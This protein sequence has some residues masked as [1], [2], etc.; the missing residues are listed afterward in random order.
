MYAQGVSLRRG[1]YWKETPGRT[2][3]AKEGVLGFFEGFEGWGGTAKLR[4]GSFP[5]GLTFIPNG[6]QSIGILILSWTHWGR[7]DIPRMSLSCSPRNGDFEAVGT[8]ASKH[9][10]RHYQ[11]YP[12]AY[13][14]TILVD[15]KSGATSRDS[16]A[17]SQCGTLLFCP[18]FWP[19]SMLPIKILQILFLLLFSLG[20]SEN[21]GFFNGW[22]LSHHRWNRWVD[23]ISLYGRLCMLK[24]SW[25]WRWDRIVSS[26][27][28]IK[29]IA[30][31]PSL[32]SQVRQYGSHDKNLQCKPPIRTSSLLIE[33][34]CKTGQPQQRVSRREF[35]R[36][37]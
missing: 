14:K 32:P 11:I 28:R 16:P 26:T 20:Y 4:K 29:G 7:S 33:G 21:D 5:E 2:S 19:A 36:Y 30:D 6:S 8:K 31:Y 24:D 17:G 12:P 23:R 3:L 1:L 13:S 35:G 37:Q 18:P 9:R 22:L 27:G 34:W 10:Q 15:D 25:S